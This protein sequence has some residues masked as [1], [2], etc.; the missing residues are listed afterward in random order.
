MNYYYLISSLYDLSI[1]SGQVPLTINDYLE[2]CK[3][4]LSD[5]DFDSL[6]HIFLFND[7]KNLAFHKTDNFNYNKPSYYEESYFHESFLDKEQFKPFISEFLYQKENDKRQFPEMLEIDELLAKFYLDID[8]IDNQFIKDYLDFELNLQNITT[9]MTMRK[10]KQDYKKFIIPA[11]EYYEN[12]IKVNAVDFGLSGDIYYI[13]RLIDAYDS[14]DLIE[15]EK[16]IEEIRFEWLDES[17]NYKVFSF[18]G[19][20]AYAVKLLSAERWSNL[21]DEKG[22]EVLD[23]LIDTIKSGITFSDEFK[24]IGG[25]K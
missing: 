18:K 13:E 16:T 6:M 24:I 7:M 12:I 17:V 9:A 10:N 11:G 4:E 8:S 23:S 3:E 25:S 20:V 22:R 15:I 1:D 21:T 19:V 2:F 14:D 5:K